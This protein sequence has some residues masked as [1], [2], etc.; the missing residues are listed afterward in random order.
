M[1]INFEV[2]NRFTG[3][4]QFTAN[5]ECEESTDFR[6]KLGLSVEWAVKNNVTLRDA[7]LTGAYLRDADLRDAQ[8]DE[9]VRL[10]RKVAK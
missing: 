1:T 8:L 5:I 3:H 10:S 4:V 7:D 9:F 2:K 6:A